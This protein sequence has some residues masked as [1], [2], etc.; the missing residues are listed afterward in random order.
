[1]S[2]FFLA[3]S[4]H[5]D[6]SLSRKWSLIV[7]S[8]TSRRAILS[9]NRFFFAVYRSKL[10][11]F[12]ISVFGSHQ[13]ALVTDSI[14]RQLHV[15]LRYKILCSYISSK[16]ADG[17]QLVEALHPVA[18]WATESLTEVSTRNITWEIKTAGA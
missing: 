1:M 16:G 12:I 18:L 6:D 8:R 7:V 15:L 2:L 13:V 11:H 14:H 5:V 4:C 9:L 3:I 10:S 17:A